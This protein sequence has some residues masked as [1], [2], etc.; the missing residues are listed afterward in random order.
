MNGPEP[1]M[2]LVVVGAVVACLALYA[3]WL[4]LRDQSR[5]RRTT[6]LVLRGV[7]LALV[8]LAVLDPSFHRA[9]RIVKPP[10]LLLALDISRS[11]SAP[12]PAGRT[13]LEAAKT[14]LSRGE[15]AQ[16]M[17][18]A[19]VET[20]VLSAGAERVENIEAVEA[21]GGRT[22]LQAALSEILRVPRA[23]EPT[24]CLLISDGADSTAR[25][26]ARVAEALGAYGVPVFCVGV[27]GEPPADAVLAGLVAP[28]SVVEGERFEVRVLARAV[29][30]ADRPLTLVLQ[31][32]GRQVAQERLPPGRTERSVRVIVSGGRPDYHRITAG[33]VPV[34]GE[35]TDANNRRSVMVR[36]E[37]REARLL[38]IEGR[39]RREYAFLRRLLLRIEDLKTVILLRKREPAEFWLDV[40]EPRRASL[41][42]AGDLRRYRAVVLA[43]INATALGSAFIGDLADFVAEGGALA[44]L[45]G[46]N[47]FG[48]GG[49]ADTTIA[50]V[51]PV[52]MGGQML[53][54]AVS[55]RLS[56]D[57]E[58]SRALRATGVTAWERLPLLDGMNAVEGVTPGAEVVM[59]GVS[60]TT[61]VG[62]L[63]VAGRSGAGRTLAV[64][65]SDTWRWRQSADADEHS[66]AAWEALW[67]T[68][69]GWLIAPRSERQVVLELGR[70]DFEAGEPVRAL[71]YVR[72]EQFQPVAEARVVLAVDG[73]ERMTA[74]ATPTTTAGEYTATLIAG[75]PGDYK[76][77]VVAHLPDGSEVADSREFTVSRPLGE[78]TDPPRPEVLEAIAAE[79]GGRYLPIERADEMVPLL[80]LKP[81]VQERTLQIRPA[82]TIAFFLVLL[83]IAGADWLLRRRWGV[84]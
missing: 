47:S 74:E 34:E 49:W 75:A 39:P 42:A 54:D 67:T 57:G 48:G 32:D 22:D 24:A 9:V 50:R 43:D 36:V 20:W 10:T 40:G 53:A 81:V 58:V 31:R 4:R 38:L 51:L 33:I 30:L 28:R 78:L 35:L 64:M 73:P 52:R 80:P 69:I 55:V 79:T 6:L 70:D 66:R 29:G 15:L 56:G 77:R 68:L 2:L 83:V 25:P 59:E 8:L 82:R 37:P 13:R 26:P 16:A 12:G 63:V 3:C 84:G 21:N 46:E 65:A 71:V 76:V 5:L 60:G 14:I 61:V 72:D 62:P 41:S 19:R 7:V 17:A 23:Q 18:S 11:M 1:R 45:G 27:S 44:M